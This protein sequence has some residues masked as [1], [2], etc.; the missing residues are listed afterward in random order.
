MTFK[1]INFV[2]ICS[3]YVFWAVSLG[4]MRGWWMSHQ[5]IFLK[6]LHSGW[7]KEMVHMD[8]LR[9]GIVLHLYFSK[10]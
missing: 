2:R 4:S 1:E 10:I 5:W 3:T 6:G 7:D 9:Y 8:S